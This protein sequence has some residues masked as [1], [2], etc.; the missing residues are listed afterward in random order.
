MKKIDPDAPRLVAQNRKVRHQYLILQELEVGLVLLGSEVKSLREGRCS[1]AEAHVRAKGGELFLVGTHIPEYVHAG[2]Q[3][4]EPTRTRKLL[5][6]KR[7]IAGLERAS[8]ERGV[9]IV[10]LSLYFLRQHAKLKIALVRGKKMHDKRAATRE[11]DDK[12]EIAREA[13]RHE[14][15]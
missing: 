9:T 11:R 14:R 6:H 13:K 10:P 15:R 8:R 3:N 1:L 7:E 2:K 12:R 5:A 4:H